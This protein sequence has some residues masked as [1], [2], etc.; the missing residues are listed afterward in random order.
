[1][2]IQSSIIKSSNIFKILRTCGAFLQEFGCQK[3][4]TFWKLSYNNTVS[5]IDFEIVAYKKTKALAKFIPL[6]CNFP[7]ELPICFGCRLSFCDGD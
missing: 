1:M 3:R 6:I 2:T 7:S 4:C 5:K